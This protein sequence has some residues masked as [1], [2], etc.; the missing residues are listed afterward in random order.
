MMLHRYRQIL[1]QQISQGNRFAVRRSLGNQ[2]RLQAALNQFSQA[3]VIDIDY[4]EQN[5]PLDVLFSSA[6]VT[7]MTDAAYRYCR[8]EP[9]M[10]VV[11]FGTGSLEHLEANIISGLRPA[12]PLESINKLN[13]LF[14]RVTHFSGN[15]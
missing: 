3:G 2:R 5:N 11:I 12:L 1:N 13:R 4:L 14:A 8:A 7:R 6:G 9:G 15:Y 10:H